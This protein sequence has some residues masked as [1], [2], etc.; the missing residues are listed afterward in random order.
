MYDGPLAK[1]SEHFLKIKEIDDKTY[2]E[3]KEIDARELLV[4]ERLDLMAKW[5]YIETYDQKS[6]MDFGKE[7]YAKHLQAFSL[8]SFSEPGNEEKDSLAKYIKV[9]NEL[10]EDIKENGFDSEVSLIPVGKDNIILDGAHRVACAAYYHKKVKVVYFPHLESKFDYEYFRG[11]KLSEE[12]IA[13]MVEKYCEVKEKNIYFSCMWP[14]ANQEQTIKKSINKITTES[15]IIYSSNVAL[16]KNGLRNFMLQ[17]YGHQKWTGD[18]ATHFSGLMGKVEGCYRPG[19]DTNIIVFEDNSFEHVLRMK[20]EIREYFH[21]GK[22]AIHISDTKEEAYLMA[23]LLLNQNSVHHLNYGTPDKYIRVYEKYK[24]V[25]SDNLAKVIYGGKTSLAV[26]GIAENVDYIFDKDEATYS[27]N[28]RNY[29]V[30]SGTRFMSLS[31]IKKEPKLREI[32]NEANALMKKDSFLLTDRKRRLLY[33]KTWADWTKKY[34]FKNQTGCSQIPF[35]YWDL[36]VDTTY[37]EKTVK[38]S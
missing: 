9:F 20:D 29:F 1:L 38:C 17:I 37:E 14:I 27:C 4:P 19:A 33:F 12:I 7:V 22:H 24:N 6:D 2:Y 23:Q 28:P 15:K 36:S 5:I 25:K 31:A 35:G 10:I 30:F 18:I 16:N 32:H 26:Y 11:R 13:Y 34:Y 8:N 21:I 3:V